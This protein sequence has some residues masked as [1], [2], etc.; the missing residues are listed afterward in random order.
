[1]LDEMSN[2]C[3]TFNTLCGRYCFIKM[4]YGITAGSEVF[5]SS[6]EQL[7]EG[8]PCKIIV[9]DI[10]LYGKNLEEHDLHLEKVMQR[11]QEINLKLNMKKCEFRVKSI[12]FVGKIG[13]AHV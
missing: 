11:L 9:H 8:L 7:M 12:S 2:Y 6:M 5:Q 13:R 1:M 3:T 10:I 4:P